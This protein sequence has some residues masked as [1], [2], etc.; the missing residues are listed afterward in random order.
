LVAQAGGSPPA[1]S[2][3]NHQNNYGQALHAVHRGIG[4]DFK[5]LLAIEPYRIIPVKQNGA[6]SITKSELPHFLGYKIR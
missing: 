5:D 3:Q 1:K 2:T 6:T 4:A